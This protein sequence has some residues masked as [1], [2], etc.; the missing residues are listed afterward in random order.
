MHR[1]PH[2]ES[3]AYRP[4]PLFA[5]VVTVLLTAEVL[6]AEL[7]TAEVLTAELLTAE[8]LTL[9]LTAA[10]LTHSCSYTQTLTRIWNE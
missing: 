10:L 6:T 2:F 5:E 8:L 7:L 4:Q 9:V 3:A 1:V